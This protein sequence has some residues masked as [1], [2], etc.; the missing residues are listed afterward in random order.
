MPLITGAKQEIARQKQEL[1]E[2]KELLEQGKG[3]INSSLEPL[4]Q[5]QAALQTCQDNI[6]QVTG[7]MEEG[8]VH[9]EEIL[10]IPEEERTQEETEF[11]E[12]WDS[13]KAGWKK[14]LPD[15][16]SKKI[17]LTAQMQGQGS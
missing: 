3:E 11:L 5:L 10:K 13:V 1:D 12:Q 17:A 6:D 7:Q 2:Q 16:I 9:Y 15:G 14:A 4:K 8:A